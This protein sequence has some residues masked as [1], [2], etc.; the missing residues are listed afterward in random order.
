MMMRTLEAGGVP[1]LTDEIRTANTDNPNGYYEF[2]P[3]KRTR[4]NAS[5]V[6]GAYDRA[7]KMVYLLLYDL[8]DS[9]TYRVVF[10][11]RNLEEVIA[12]Q[13][14]MLARDGQAGGQID[15]QKM[16]GL[17]AGHLAKV[18][19]WLAGK[20][21]FQVLDVDFGDVL[22]NPGPQMARIAEFLGGGL[23]TDAMTGIVDPALYRNRR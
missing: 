15:D 10:M 17:F 4:E 7:V 18:E 22:S 14:K 6:D 5:W 9:H 13:N 11:K 21:N 23:D 2:E 20:D 1:A 12:S 16:I 3:V 19:Q 8:P